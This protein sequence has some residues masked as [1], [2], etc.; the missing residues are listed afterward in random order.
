MY[1]NSNDVQTTATTTAA[2]VLNLLSRSFQVAP[3]PAL[4][5]LRTLSV[6]NI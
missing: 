2:L 5:T 4:L 6:I 1:L 3:Q